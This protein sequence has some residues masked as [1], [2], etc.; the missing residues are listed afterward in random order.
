[1]ALARMSGYDVVET[2]EALVTL[3]LAAPEPGQSV[4]GLREGR[5]LRSV[6]DEDGQHWW[7]GSGTGGAKGV[8][9]A[10]KRGGW[11]S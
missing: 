9:V 7:M 2:G 5:K 4:Q 6:R 1:M 8:D 3:G 10:P 11:R